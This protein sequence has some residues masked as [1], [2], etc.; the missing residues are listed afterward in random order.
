MSATNTSVTTA[1]PKKTRKR[2]NPAGSEK[3][4]KPKKAKAAAPKKQASEKKTKASAKGKA[5][6]KKQASEKKKA[7]AKPRAKKPT[8]AEK[9]AALA[10]QQQQAASTTTT[11]DGVNGT[12]EKKTKKKSTSGKKSNKNKIQTPGS[13][14]IRVYNSRFESKLPADSDEI[15]INMAND[16]KDNKWGCLSIFHV[17][18]DGL[19]LP[20][21]VRGLTETKAKTVIGAWNGLAVFQNEGVE[22]KW[23]DKTQASKLKRNP[24]KDKTKKVE[25][26]A[27]DADAKM[28]TGEDGTPVEAPKKAKKPKKVRGHYIGHY[29]APDYFCGF[30]TAVHE[31][32]RPL[33]EQKIR[34]YCGRQYAELLEMVR[35][36][37]KLILLDHSTSE[38]FEHYSPNISGGA[39]LKSML[40]KDAGLYI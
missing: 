6:P 18:E 14:Q 34:K 22:A 24:S 16:D 1:A 11:T 33:Y 7:S 10:A 28:A 27:A 37:K 9:K 12:E 31:I 29:V 5:A 2:A 8:A 23:F 35:Q 21:R 39:I 38:N 26:P 3:K 19:D 30:K 17:H 36:G 13:S 20:P 4:S 40:A 32:F 25:A 15:R